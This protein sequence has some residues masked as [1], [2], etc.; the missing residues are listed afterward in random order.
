MPALFE[1]VEPAVNEVSFHNLLEA[2]KSAYVS[3]FPE[4]KEKAKSA[5]DQV[6][7]NAYLHGHH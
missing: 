6:S 2:S 5:A 4:V 1:D 3:A 7:H